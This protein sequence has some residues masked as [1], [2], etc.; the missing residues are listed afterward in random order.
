MYSVT[1]IIHES[2]WKNITILFEASLTKVKYC[3]WQLFRNVVD[4]FCQPDFAVLAVS[5]HMKN[6]LFNNEISFYIVPGTLSLEEQSYSQ[7]SLPTI[8][9]IFKI[10]NLSPC[11]PSWAMFVHRYK[12]F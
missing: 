10:S 3:E 11:S 9:I 4:H 5:K 7:L 6:K 1:S 8:F 12:S 2:L